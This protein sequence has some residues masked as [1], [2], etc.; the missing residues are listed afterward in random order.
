MPLYTLGLNHTSAPVSVR[1]KM[2]FSTEQMGGALQELIHIA[3]VEEAAILSTCNRTEVYCQLADLKYDDHVVQWLGGF[4][5]FD[6][7]D[8]KP[9]LYRYQDRSAVR[10][11]LR[12]ACGLDSMIVGEPQILGQLK[13][14]Y[15]SAN[16]AG[17]LGRFLSRLFQYAFA[18]AKEVR[19]D[20]AIGASPVSVAFA[21]VSLAKQIFADL[22][23]ESALLIGA[24][25]TVELVARHLAG[26]RVGNLV[27][28]NRSVA[29]A[30]TLAGQFNGRGIGLPQIVHVLPQCDIVVSS[31]ASP[32]PILGKGLV[33]RALKIRKHRPIF[34]VDIAVP[35]DVEP[36][37]GELDDVYLYTVDD[38]HEVIQDNLESR[39]EAADQADE[40]IQVKVEDFMAWLRSQDAVSSIRSF[41]DLAERQRLQT[42]AKAKHMLKQGKPAEEVLEYLA[43][44]LTNKLT[45]G[46]TA[47]LNQA[48]REGRHD[49]LDAAAILLNLSQYGK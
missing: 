32:L 40:M 17:T 33:E 39:R 11:A 41:R 24:G 48:G 19:T 4:H 2:A 31:T 16:Q 43:Y 27:I 22:S 1:E 30:R 38:L 36:E 42:L 46:P 14:A 49:L 13:L 3:G 9:F 26:N 34:M 10:H 20:T 47:A 44:T 29:R 35:R 5:H 18:T 45:H 8:V 25:E 6:Q 37:V 23:G 15:Q 12:V 7:Q 28:A 21:A